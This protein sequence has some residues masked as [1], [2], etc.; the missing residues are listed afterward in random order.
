ML[1][2]QSDEAHDFVAALE[3]VPLGSEL[4]H[5]VHPRPEGFQLPSGIW[6]AMFACYAL[7]ISALAVATGGDGHARMAIA[8]SALFMLVYFST[9]LILGALGGA[10]RSPVGKGIPLQTIYGPLNAREVWSQVLIIPVALALFGMGIL[11]V[12]SLV[13]V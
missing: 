8:I 2:A 3:K 9:A 4:A 12:T 11:I 6:K 10:D 5:A 1:A 13:G 7:F